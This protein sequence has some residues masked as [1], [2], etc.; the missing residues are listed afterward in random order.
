LYTRIFCVSTLGKGVFMG[1]DLWVWK[2]TPYNVVDRS[3]VS[4]ELK[5]QTTRRHFPDDST[6]SS[7]RR[8]NL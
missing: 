7:Q 2:V 4:G 6:A 5:Y 1:E 8:E 3:H